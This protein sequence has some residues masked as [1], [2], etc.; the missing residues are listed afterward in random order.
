MG[1]KKYKRTTIELDEQLYKRTKALAVEKDR[2]M[3][4]IISEALEEK[5]AREE[6]KKETIDS[7]F[8]RDN[9]VSNR[10]VKTLEKF[11]SRDAAMLLFTKKCDS[12]GYDPFLISSDIISDEFLISLCNAVTNLSNVEKGECLKALKNALEVH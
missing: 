2:T 11:I 5:L 3:R 12:R 6:E 9:P 1:T 8:L 10:I 7:D 4:D